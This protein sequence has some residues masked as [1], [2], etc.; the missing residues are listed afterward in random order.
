[1][2]KAMSVPLTESRL[3]ACHQRP[4]TAENEGFATAFS[5]FICY[6]SGFHVTGFVSSLLS[7][8]V[9]IAV[10]S[11]LLDTAIRTSPSRFTRTRC[12]HEGSGE[13]PERCH[14]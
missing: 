1:M 4:H 13:G 9:P 2:R 3:D 14:G 8:G 11:K 6:R 7:N 10:V 5:C 12:R